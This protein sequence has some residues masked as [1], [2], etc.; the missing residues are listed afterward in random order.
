MYYRE[1]KVVE[2]KIL[3]IEILIL[4]FIILINFWE[5]FLKGF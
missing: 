2:G 3:R 1:G 4:K 5:N